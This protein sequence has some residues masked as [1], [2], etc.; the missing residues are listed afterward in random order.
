MNR[1][2]NA[3]GLYINTDSITRYFQRRD[4]SL[5]IEFDDGET[6]VFGPERAVYTMELLEGRNH[7]VQVIPAIEPLYLVY[8]STEEGEQKYFAEAVHYLALCADG[9]VYGAR[10]QDGYF[11]VGAVSNYWGMFTRPQLLE[12]FPNIEIWEEQ[13]NEESRT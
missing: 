4:N 5:V 11:D 1:F 9:D 8:Y 12:Q 10:I 3:N 7:I 6:Q 13:N 2:I